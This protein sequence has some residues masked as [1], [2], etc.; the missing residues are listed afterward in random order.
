MA[1][2]L[3]K[4]EQEFRIFEVL[5]PLAGINVVPGSIIQ[6]RPPAPDI[7][8]DVVGIGHMNFELLAL[9][10]E[11]TRKR[12]SNMFNTKS[13]WA[14]SLRGIPPA[15]LARIQAEFANVHLSVHFDEMA[16]TRDRSA[17]LSAIQ[18]ELLRLP[19][20]YAG[21]LFTDITLPA[22]LHSVSIF[23]TK[24][25]DGPNVSAPSA[26]YWMPP[27]LNKIEE[28]LL[29]K[30]YTFTAPLELFA[31]SPHDEPDGHINSLD[32]IQAC[33]NRNLPGS[34]F[35]RVHVFNL[36]FLKHIVMIP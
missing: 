26:G 18:K 34:L 33:I 12:L 20:G 25:T 28:K 11:S 31:Y 17:A 36:G 15:E 5:A 13:A 1:R 21:P 29:E 16:G 35:T 14:R 27:Q 3:T 23:R 7:Q 2:D 10:D 32:E 24:R 6:A 4:Q 30:S 9:D 22:R 8:C 19:S